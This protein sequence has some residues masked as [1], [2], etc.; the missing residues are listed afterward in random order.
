MTAAKNGT[1]TQTYTYGNSDWKDLLTAVNGKTI[2]Y[3]QSGNPTNYVTYGDV[4]YYIEWENGRQLSYANCYE[5][6]WQAAYCYDANGVRTYKN[7]DGYESVYTTQNGKVVREV[8]SNRLHKIILDFIY[9]ESG[10]PFALNCSTDSGDSFTMYY[11]IL[12]LQGD[13]VKLVT[14]SGETVASYE[15]DAWGKVLSATGSMAL[16]N[17][18]RYRGYYY[19]AETGFYYLQSRYYDP[20]NRRFIN[21]DSYASTGQGFVGVNMFAYCNNN[22]IMASDP[23]GHWLIGAIIGLIIATGVALTGCSSEQERKWPENCKYQY[24]SG[25]MMKNQQNNCYSY[26]FEYGTVRDPGEMSGVDIFPVENDGK[27]SISR[28]R[29]GVLNDA[30]ESGKNVM[31][32]SDN[33]LGSYKTK[34]PA[35]AYLI[36]AKL[37]S[38]KNDYHFAV[39]LENGVWVDKPGKQE[40]RYGAIDGFSSIWQIDDRIYDSET[41]YFLYTP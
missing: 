21:A 15:Y 13:V 35:G 7:A 18:L 6:Q 12:N 19:D 23:S 28:L 32:V 10:R 1:V 22:P 4:E 20:A 36:A 37:T 8:R 17:P 33:N 39:L 31:Y 14:A 27:I 9:D 24:E 5:E 30:S 38:D 40:T 2:T 16:M 26:A 41:L 3:D 29:D 25:G 34:R 11:Y